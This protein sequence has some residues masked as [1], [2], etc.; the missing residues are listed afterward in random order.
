MV[1]KTE[2]RSKKTLFAE[3]AV[4]VK[5]YES[6][7]VDQSAS[8]KFEKVFGPTPIDNFKIA[9]KGKAELV[10]EQDVIIKS[11]KNIEVLQSRTCRLQ[12]S[13]NFHAIDAI[14]SNEAANQNMFNLP[15][16]MNDW[17]RQI[18]ND[19]S[20]E[21]S[22]FLEGT[23]TDQEISEKERLYFIDLAIDNIGDKRCF[24]EQVKGLFLNKR[25]NEWMS[26][27]MGY[28][29]M[30]LLLSGLSIVMSAFQYREVKSNQLQGQ[31]AAKVITPIPL[32]L[33]TSWTFGSL[34][35]HILISFT[36]LFVDIA[37][38]LCPILALFGVTIAFYTISYRAAATQQ[39]KLRQSDMLAII[40]FVSFTLIV[41]SPRIM[42]ENFDT[43]AVFGFLWMP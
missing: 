22:Y 12:T 15:K 11:H 17:A 7:Y 4:T 29:I 1:K 25:K 42:T 34:L 28:G 33:L 21:N 20:N 26:R 39:L 9:D 19:Y 14:D 30:Y 3:V 8:L 24:P 32:I 16:L 18:N 5:L 40:F 13:L 31:A 10:L 27:F 23:G 35:F 37:S 36:M 38:Q 2:K 6:D 41:F 43:V